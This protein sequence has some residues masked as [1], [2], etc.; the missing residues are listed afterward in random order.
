M[1]SLKIITIALFGLGFLAFIA[2][3]FLMRSTTGYKVQDGTVVYRYI[4]NLNWKKKSFQLEGAD[5]E[6]FKTFGFS[7]V[8]GKDK[9]HV[10]LSGLKIQEAEPGSFK[11]LEATYQYARDAK[12]LYA[13]T[14]KIGDHPD[15]FKFL[16]AGFAVDGQSAFFRGEL[17]DGADGSS[18]E[19]MDDKGIYA[20][21]RQHIFYIGKMI[22]DSHSASFKK[23]KHSFYADK[24]A[25]Y[26]TSNR[27][28]GADEMTFKVLSD[29]YAKDAEQVYYTY[30]TIPMA[31]PQSFEIRKSKYGGY[32]A[33]DDQRKY[34]FDKV[35]DH[36]P[37]SV[38]QP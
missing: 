6:T 7:G 11:I 33:Q 20:K 16:G 32:Y 10:Y 38:Q 8:Y 36:F 35:I 14:R 28:P 17:I 22:P 15:G 12:H 9:N 27:I 4:D 29:R 24:H 34:N 2:V 31:S 5:A 30:K 19:L 3:F 25:V 21:D 23:I 13:G 26:Y 37:E 1:E 18:F